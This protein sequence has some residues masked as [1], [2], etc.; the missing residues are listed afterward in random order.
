LAT[1]PGPRIGFREA[2]STP[3]LVQR[4]KAEVAGTLL[5]AELALAWGLACNSAGGTHHAHRGFGSGYCCLNDLA[6]AAHELLR[7]GAVSRVLILDLDV[8]QVG[9]EGNLG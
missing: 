2:T 6:F 4:T 8:H 5:T 7:R 3:L 1:P 9:G